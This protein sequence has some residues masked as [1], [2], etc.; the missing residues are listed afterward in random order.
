MFYE[1]AGLDFDDPLWNTLLDQISLEEAQYLATF[2]GP[3]IPGIS[4]IGTVETYMTENDGNG[5][6]INLRSSKDKDAPWAISD[7]D[8]NGNWNPE[9][10]ACAPLVAASFNNDLYKAVGEFVGEESL[11]T[12]IPIL[13]GPGLNTHRHAYNGRNGEYYSEDPVLAGN[14][15]MEFAIGALDYGLIAAPKHFAFNDQETYRKR[16][17]AFYAGAACP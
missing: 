12:G 1:M 14:A 6:C 7:D 8:P 4:S 13:W 2:G 17:G 15:A 11:F 3:S 5:I 9:V 16:R 10:F